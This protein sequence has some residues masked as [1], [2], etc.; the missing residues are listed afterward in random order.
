LKVTMPGPSNWLQKV[1]SVPSAG[2]PSS[3][4]VPPRV[5]VFGRVMVWFGP[6]LTTGAMFAGSAL[7]VTSSLTECSPSPAVRRST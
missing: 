7:M 5:A 4:T 6:A 1:V 3:L 2:R